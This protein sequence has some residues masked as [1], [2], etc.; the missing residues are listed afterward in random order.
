MAASGE[1]KKMPVD[2][3]VIVPADEQKDVKARLSK[4][5][6]QPKRLDQA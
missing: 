2:F 3:M 4:V 6:L 5:V 1:T